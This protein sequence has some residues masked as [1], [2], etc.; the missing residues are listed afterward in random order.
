MMMFNNPNLTLRI[1][2]EGVAS[3][4][5]R[6]DLVDFN[7]TKLEVDTLTCLVRF[8]D[9]KGNAKVKLEYH[10]CEGD[11]PDSAFRFSLTQKSFILANKVNDI[12]SSPTLEWNFEVALTSPNQV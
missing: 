12:W 4:K 7:E 3:F 1:T 11:D 10:F 6:Y 9:E 8:V 5:N 2:A